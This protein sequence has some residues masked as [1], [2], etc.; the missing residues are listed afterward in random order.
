MYKRQ[1]QNSSKQHGGVA[2]A[3]RVEKKAGNKYVK[4]K[5][6]YSDFS[7]S[8]KGFQEKCFK[9]GEKGHLKKDC[10]ARVMPHPLQTGKSEEGEEKSGEQRDLVLFSH[11]Q[12]RLNLSERMKRMFTNNPEAVPILR[13]PA[14]DG[15]QCVQPLFEL[16]Y[17]LAPVH[18]HEK[19]GVR[20]E[21][22]YACLLYTSP[23]PRD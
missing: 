4:S 19:N 6:E 2:L 10:L 22:W 11:S 21:P 7:S 5:R 3:A 8:Q 16:D 18:T 1:T 14:A 15:V 23:S 20:V 12:T 13:S 17:D 9:C